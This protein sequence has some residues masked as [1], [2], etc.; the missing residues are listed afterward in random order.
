[1]LISICFL[2]IFLAL[3]LLLDKGYFPEKSKKTLFIVII[4]STLCFEDFNFGIYFFFNS[5]LTFI[6][7][8]IKNKKLRIII[9][10]L[11]CLIF[12]N[13]AQIGLYL[14]NTLLTFYFSEV[15]YLKHSIFTLPFVLFSLKYLTDKNKFMPKL[16]LEKFFTVII[17]LVLLVTL[18]HPIVKTFG[19]IKSLNYFQALVI[20]L[21]SASIVFILNKI[22]KVLNLNIGIEDHQASH[23]LILF[24]SII[25]IRPSILHVS[26]GLILVTI[27]YYNYK[28]S[29]RTFL[30]VNFL[31]FGLLFLPDFE[32][33][34]ATLTGLLSW[35]SI[36]LYYNEFY[37]LNSI[38]GDFS[39]FVPTLALLYFW[40]K[41]KDKSF[42]K[43]L[44]KE[45]K[46]KLP[47]FIISCLLILFIF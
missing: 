26:I 35:S 6:L 44:D 41:N 42:L 43:L 25:L 40:T 7:F 12:F 15:P 46:I 24:A 21:S 14:N 17:L 30:F 27:Q 34:K 47:Q 16:E 19:A 36:F 10:S 38:G 1:M 20:L 45:H 28:N 8:K 39:L 29:F 33:I 37:I 13:S 23:P 5:I 31:L 4:G 2:F 11:I 3:I 18:G 9:Y 22:S 32:T